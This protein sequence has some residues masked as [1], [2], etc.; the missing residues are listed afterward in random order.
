MICTIIVPENAPEWSCLN[1][2]ESPV[3]DIKQEILKI[4]RLL[5]MG[6]YTEFYIN[7]EY[8]ISLW[9]AELIC[10]IKQSHPIRMHIAVPHEEQCAQW[11]EHYR[12]RYFHLHEAADSVHFVSKRFSKDCYQKTEK[13][14]A[15]QSDL[16]VIFG[17]LE[18]ASSIVRYAESINVPTEI[19]SIITQA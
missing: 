6:G 16:V 13:F 11:T 12:D 5:I 1:E 7:C 10:K 14:M 3:S 19:I 4:L 2:Y 9:T 8:T 17:C 18:N 15:E